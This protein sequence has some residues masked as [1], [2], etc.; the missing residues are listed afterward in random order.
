[1][2][3][4][5][6]TPIP[7]HGTS[8]Q[9]QALPLDIILGVIEHVPFPSAIGLSNWDSWNTNLLVLNREIYSTIVSRLY[10]TVVLRTS[11]T[12]LRFLDSL[13]ASPH[14]SPLVQNLWIN[15][16]PNL[17][18]AKSNADRGTSLD[19]RYSLTTNVLAVI[20]LTPN[21]RRLAVASPLY[22]GAAHVSN[23]LPDGIVDLV[24]PSLWLGMAPNLMGKSILSHLPASLKVLRIRGRV[25]AEEARAI[26]AD[27]P[28][29]LR[30]VHVRVFGGTLLGDIERFTSVLIGEHQTILSLE[31]TVLP[32]QEVDVLTSLSDLADKYTDVDTKTLITSNTTQN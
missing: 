20:A 16:E 19:A 32:K 31:L 1:M 17:K 6:L 5:P 12:V 28:P 13:I 8:S 15:H 10:H 21:A 23:S 30:Y 18:N 2:V 24:I 25:G 3:S 11:N 7:P 27:S 22:Y 26:V 29:M 9:A 4:S 14:L